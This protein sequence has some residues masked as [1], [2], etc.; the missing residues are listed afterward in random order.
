MNILIDTSPLRNKNALRGVGRYTKELVN[1]LRA[2][3][4]QHT[5]YTS[6]DRPASVDLIHYPFFDLF[7]PTLPLVKKT[8]TVVTIHD[9]IPL[10]F[11]RHYPVGI[12]GRIGFLYQI[13]SL[14]SISHVI[15]DSACSKRDLNDQL[16]LSGDRV[17]SIP[18]AASSEFAKQTNSVVEAVRRKYNIPKNYVLYVGDIN[19]N[20]NL[21][22]LIRVMAQI[23]DITLV[24]V[25]NAVQDIHIPEGKAIHDAIEQ[26]G[27][28]KYVR[29]VTNVETQDDLI[30]LYSG[31]RVYVQP[32]LYEGF[33]LPVVEAM[34]CRVPVVSSCGGSLA[35]VVGDAGVQFN[36]TDSV[37]CEAAIR[38]AL[39]L[40]DE[41]RAKVI[42][43]AYEYSEK[44]SWERVAQETLGVYDNVL[45]K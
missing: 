39:R 32:S 6:D 30:A 8:K 34:R 45:R 33:G 43:K 44:F 40:D 13:L 29:L 19:Y 35:E 27:S 16:K 23:P 17:T 26:Q 14:R 1:A 28:E 22:F 25:G 12:K 18:L 2:L 41:Q 15:T 4:T 7:F 37:G 11:P 31:A 36:P 38:K 21:P 24:L 42:K 10:I 3:P 5:F 9:V 20:K